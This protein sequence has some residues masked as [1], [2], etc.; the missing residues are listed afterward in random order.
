MVVR[1]QYL[2]NIKALNIYLCFSSLKLTNATII[3][4][5]YT[6]LDVYKRQDKLE[7]VISTLLRTPYTFPSFRVVFLKLF[8][9]AAV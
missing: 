1:S 5:S 4:V 8:E 9:D 7:V 3:A 2:V 6:H